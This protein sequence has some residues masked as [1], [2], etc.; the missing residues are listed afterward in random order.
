MKNEQTFEKQL[1][2]FD[3][4]EFKRQVGDFE[5]NRDL[6][7]QIAEL[8]EGL[9]SG[10]ITHERIGQVFAGNYTALKEASHQAIKKE[11]KH[12]SLAEVTIQRTN[13]RLEEFET[14]ATRLVYR[15]NQIGRRL[16]FNTV[17]PLD[18]FE[19]NSDGRFYVPAETI[20]KIKESCS[21]FLSTEE[22]RELHEALNLVAT[23]YTRFL[24]G[25]GKNTREHLSI[26]SPIENFLLQENG[27]FTARPDIDYSQLAR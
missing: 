8:Y 15:F 12:Q 27:V 22:E 11:I 23:G 6:L 19:I 1:I 3:E 21:N 17:T 18:W 16:A 25:W 14:E 4:T 24:A 9:F 2:N 5:K 13:E 26:Y 10:K 20:A 7:N